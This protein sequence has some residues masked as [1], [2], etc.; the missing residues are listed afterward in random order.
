MFIAGKA[1]PTAG[2]YPAGTG[3]DSQPRN[4]SFSSRWRNRQTQHAQDVPGAARGG[5]TP[6]LDTT[7]PSFNGQGTRLL[8]GGWGFESSREC[9]H[10]QPV[11]GLVVQPGERRPRN[12]E[13]VGAKPTES[14]RPVAITRPRGPVGQG[15]ALRT[16]R[17]QVRLLPGTPCRFRSLAEQSPRKRPSWVRFPEPAP[18]VHAAVA[19]QTGHPP[20]KR[21]I[22]G[23]TPAGSSILGIQRLPVRR[24]RRRTPLVSGRQ[25]VRLR[26]SAPTL[27]QPLKP[28]P[29][30]VGYL[31]LGVRTPNRLREQAVSSHGNTFVR[32]I[33]L[34]RHQRPP[35]DSGRRR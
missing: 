9:H 16:R 24:L 10:Q 21:K 32:A 33:R 18:R 11:R 3:C 6:L 14:T 27:Q 35:H 19:Q 30:V 20:P 28:G 22:A 34:P 29:A 7:L 1:R 5:S 4:H 17:S 8:T 31:V 26:P 25:S 23:A 2:S 15:A 13:V 12:A